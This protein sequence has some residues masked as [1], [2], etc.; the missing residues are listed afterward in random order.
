MDPLSLLS[1]DAHR[2]GGTGWRGLRKAQCRSQ[3]D[4]L[5]TPCLQPAVT[6]RP[7]R[8]PSWRGQG[9]SAGDTRTRLPLSGETGQSSDLITQEGKEKGGE[10]RIRVLPLLYFV[11]SPS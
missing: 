1:Q 10:H 3:G 4:D 6:Q 7:Q 11:L 5:I 2:K 9:G 8:H